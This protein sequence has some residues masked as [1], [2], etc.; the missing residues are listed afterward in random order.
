MN[1]K[2]TDDAVAALPLHA[3]RA[4]LLEE[5]VMSTPTLE[6]RPVETA[7]TRRRTT[8]LVPAAAA[9]V[10]LALAA[11]TAWWSSGRGGAGDGDHA[12]A[13]PTAGGDFVV[14]DAPGWTATD[15]YSDRYGGEV[16]WEKGRQDF[17]ISWYPADE[18]QS[19]VED[20]RHIRQTPVDGDPL[21][22]LGRD[23]QMW[24]YSATDHTAIRVA[25]GDWFL[26][27]RG[28]G[29]DVDA[30]RALLTRLRAVD[31]AGFEAAMPQTFV[32]GSERQGTIHTM[33]D[34]IGRYVDP[35]FPP[36]ATRVG[37]SSNAVDPYQLGVDVAG[38]VACSW[39]DDLA[40]AKRAGDAARVQRDADVLA[41]AR[42][43]PVL[44]DMAA[45]GDYPEVLWGLLPAVEK[46]RVPKDY[47]DALGCE[48]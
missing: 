46:G 3:G 24:A 14:L 44:K 22:V 2:L 28:S 31:R 9:V 27:F 5:I 13:G 23:A 4:E 39:L 47:A 43:W 7:R 25:Q 10:V 40:E 15:A 34:G 30:Y 45:D 17:D 19:Y 8:W 16:G 36:E 6:D 35:L 1:P 12:V 20:R 11:G 21:E 42:Q 48:G 33:L 32:D 29:M 18:Y 41:T 38:A 37:V 26:E